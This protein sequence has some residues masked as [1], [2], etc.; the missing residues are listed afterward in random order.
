MERGE[1]KY[2]F[3]TC[4]FVNLV[5]ETA[6]TYRPHLEAQRLPI[7]LRTARRPLLVNGDRDAL[8]QII[9]NL[10]SNAEKYSEA[11]KEIRVRLDAADESPALRR[12]E[13]SRS[14]PRRAAMAAKKK[15]SNNFIAPTIPSAAASRAPASAS[16]SPVKSPAPTAAKS[17]TNPR[18]R[19]QLLYAPLPLCPCEKSG[20]EPYENK[21]SHRRR[22]PPHPPGPRRS[23]EKRRL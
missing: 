5:R 8:A 23:H 9:V 16:L 3:Q 20:Y 6:E 12:S 17:F 11:D 19:R 7:R 21:D 10:L 18:R 14:R 15:S 4:D 13:G 2:N 1:K 22:R